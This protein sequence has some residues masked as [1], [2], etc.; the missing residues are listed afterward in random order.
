MAL[1]S[2]SASV[3]SS[4]RIK[5][6]FFALPPACSVAFGQ[7]ERPD[8]L[9]AG[10]GRRPGSFSCANRD[11][12]SCR[13]FSRGFERNQDLSPTILPSKAEW[14]ARF[15][16][17]PSVRLF[18]SMSGRY[19]SSQALSWTKR[20]SVSADPSLDGPPRFLGGTSV[21][22]VGRRGS[23]GGRASKVARRIY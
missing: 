14:A 1:I 21:R 12:R 4:W 19:S 8:P 20:H 17:A 9:S 16:L 6:L 7:R 3:A 15:E 2:A 5:K 18:E 13:P 23:C 22:K 11:T 10:T